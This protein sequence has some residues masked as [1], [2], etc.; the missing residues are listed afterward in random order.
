VETI[1]LFL[2]IFKQALYSSIRALFLRVYLREVLGR[3]EM[4]IDNIE[5]RLTTIEAHQN[6]KEG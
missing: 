3:I 2:D 1:E 6:G 4:R 5:V